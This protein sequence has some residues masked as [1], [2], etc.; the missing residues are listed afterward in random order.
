LQ[1]GPDVAG[2]LRRIEDRW[3]AEGFP[4]ATRVAA[5]TDE[6][7]AQALDATKYS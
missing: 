4:D 6:E 7:V 3:V 1:A 5:I 2:T